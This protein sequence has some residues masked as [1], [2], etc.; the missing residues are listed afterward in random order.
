MTYTGETLRHGLEGAGLEVLS[1]GV[2]LAAGVA[3]A[4]VAIGSAGERFETHAT[5]DLA[6]ACA[7][8]TRQVDTAHEDLPAA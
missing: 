7:D 3:F 2:D 8:L 5:A 4:T 1:A 6:Q